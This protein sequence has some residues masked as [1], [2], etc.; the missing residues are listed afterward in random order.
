MSGISRQ[1]SLFLNDYLYFSLDAGGST[2]VR[3]SSFKHDQHKIEV[4]LERQSWHTLAAC[5]SPSPLHKRGCI[6]RCIDGALRRRAASRITN[7]ASAM[8]LAE[9][10]RWRKSRSSRRD[11]SPRGT[12][13]AL[14]TRA[15][16]SPDSISSFRL[17]R[18]PFYA[19][20]LRLYDQC[21]VIL[22][23]LLRELC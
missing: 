12:F 2:S 1:L 4:T 6:D 7:K 16:D 10:F 9:L 22:S 14:V 15:I 13:P 21:T 19:R 8:L 23:R 3:R 5:F 18:G 11:G 20:R 17:S